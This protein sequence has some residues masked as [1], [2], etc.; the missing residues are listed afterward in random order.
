[1]EKARINARPRV[2]RGTQAKPLPLLPSGP[3]GVCGRPLHGAR[4]LTSTHPSTAL[5]SRRSVPFRQ[6][7]VVN[8]SNE[9][10]ATPDVL[11]RSAVIKQ[12]PSLVPNQ[13]FNKHNVGDLPIRSQSFRGSKTG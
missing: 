5:A 11:I 12:P 13:S 1:M 8:L 10:T 3:G 2:I 4:S 9:S 6:F 7:S